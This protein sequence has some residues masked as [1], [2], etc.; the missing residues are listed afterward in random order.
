MDKIGI[1][2]QCASRAVCAYADVFLGKRPGCAF[3]GASVL[4]R[5]TTVFNF[6]TIHVACF[7]YVYS[8]QTKSYVSMYVTEG[9]V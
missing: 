5:K 2:Y 4:I 7:I 9:R 8:T 6:V 3:I 1:K